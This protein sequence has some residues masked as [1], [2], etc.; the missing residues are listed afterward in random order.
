[1]SEGKEQLSNCATPSSAQPEPQAPLT[2]VP[3]GNFTVVGN[4][5]LLIFVAVDAWHQISKTGTWAPTDWEI[6]LFFSTSGAFAIRS[7]IHKYIFQPPV[8]K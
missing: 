6:A 8:K 3:G 5:L 2:L 1:M 4:I 7:A